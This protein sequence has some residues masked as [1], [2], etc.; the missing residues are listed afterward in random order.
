MIEVMQAYRATDGRL[1]PDKKE[2][3]N[4]QFEID[5]ADSIA[6]FMASEQCPYKKGVQARMI[7]KV[8]MGWLRFNS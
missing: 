1:F 8:L 2:A 5:H 6:A 4:H 3:E 7:T